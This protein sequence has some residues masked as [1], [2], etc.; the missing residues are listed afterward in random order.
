M[1]REP[2]ESVVQRILFIVTG[3]KTEHI[4]VDKCV[5]GDT[6]VAVHCR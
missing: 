5:D 1:S 6:S 2:H 4:Y 3:P